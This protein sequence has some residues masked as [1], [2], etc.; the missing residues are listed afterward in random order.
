MHRALAWFAAFLGMT[1]AAAH[2]SAQNA[3]KEAYPQSVTSRPITLPQY[4]F[5]VHAEAM[6]NI[7]NN[8]VFGSV[9]LSPDAYFG[10]TDD[11]QIGINHSKTMGVYNVPGTAPLCIG[12]DNECTGV[13]DQVAVDGL[14][15]VLNKDQ[16]QL[17]VHGI[18]G[19]Q[20]LDPFG[21]AL[22]AGVLGKWKPAEIFALEF[23]PGLGIGIT[24]RDSLGAFRAVS[25][26]N[27]EYLYLPARGTIQAT[28][29]LS[30]FMDLYMVLPFDHAGDLVRLGT[31]LGGQYAIT[32]KIDV[33]GEF[34]LPVLIHGDAYRNTGFDVRQLGVF[35]N[36]RF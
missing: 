10:I 20:S 29:A 22:R 30:F 11:I 34:R 28:E 31:N 14:F 32:N 35:A 5:E 36:F 8:H 33:G 3:S 26:G 23:D 18:V 19:G 25:Y 17:G 16:F 24:N 1:T 7:S 13:Y 6:F 4:M 2:A 9:S 12:G 15:R 27:K 21:L